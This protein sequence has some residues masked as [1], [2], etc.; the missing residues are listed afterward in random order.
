MDKIN[1]RNIKIMHCSLPTNVCCLCHTNLL[2]LK[3][4]LLA[5]LFIGGHEEHSNS[6]LAWWWKLKSN[7]LCG[8]YV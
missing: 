4:A 6:I 3:F 2:K 5:T 1:Q 8:L 7:I